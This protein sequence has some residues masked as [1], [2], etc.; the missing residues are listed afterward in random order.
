MAWYSRADED[1]VQ[2]ATSITGSAD[3]AMYPASHLADIDGARSAKLTT[4]TGSY[5]FAF[6]APVTPLAVVLIFQYL[7]AGLEVRIQGNASDSWGSPSFDQAITIPA[8]RKDGPSYQRWTRNAWALL[9]EPSPYAFWRVV[10]VGAN[11]Q[12]VAIGRVM[13]PSAIHEVE[14][15]PDA[16]DVHEDDDAWEIVQPTEL[17]VETYYML[18]GPRWAFSGGLVATDLDAGTAPVQEASDFRDLAETA[19]GRS[20]P[21]LFQAFDWVD[22]KLVRFDEAVRRR[23][24]RVGGYQVWLFAVREVARGLIWP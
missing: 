2:Q 18:G 10:I 22:P 13:L 24:H 9:T 15:L 11:S 23:T 1:L 8:K 4:T 16:G 21:F 3:D 20:A 5:V 14:I 19:E 7:D 12:A 6:A 17:G